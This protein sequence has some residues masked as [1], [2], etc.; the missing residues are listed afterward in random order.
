MCANSYSFG[1]GLF[2]AS[3]LGPAAAADLGN[4][5]MLGHLP[6]KA[7]VPGSVVVDRF[8]T[9]LTALKG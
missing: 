9:V 1:S 8:V 4:V 6:G 7:L 3:W 5:E 2:A